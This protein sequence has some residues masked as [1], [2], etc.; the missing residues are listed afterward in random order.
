MESLSKSVCGVY[1][2]LNRKEIVNWINHQNQ[3]NTFSMTLKR[4]MGL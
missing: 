2:V 4:E 3:S 1:S